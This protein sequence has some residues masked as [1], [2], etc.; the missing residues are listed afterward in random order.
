MIKLIFR[1]LLI[2]MIITG[3][4]N[5]GEAILPET[6]EPITVELLE[7]IPIEKLG[8]QGTVDGIKQYVIWIDDIKYTFSSDAVF[9]TKDVGYTSRSDFKK[10]HKV[11]FILDSDGKI[12]F[13]QRL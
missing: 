13:L 4:A 11:G 7:R 6:G 8:G 2:I 10:G 3:T 1:G 12:A 9:L 5:A